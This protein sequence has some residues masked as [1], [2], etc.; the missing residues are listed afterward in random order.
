MSGDM[1]RGN[2]R[3]GALRE[4]SLHASIKNYYALS[5]DLIEAPINGYMIDIVRGSCL[6]EIQ[7]GNFSSIKQK[8]K[9][10]LPDYRVHL[11]YPLAIDKWILKKN[12]DG[13]LK[14]RKSP[15][16][17]RIEHIFYELVNISQLINDPNF[18]FEVLFTREQEIRVPVDHTTRKWGWRRKK[19]TVSDRQLLEVVEHQVFRTVMDYSYF[20]DSLG[21]DIPFTSHDL[22]QSLKIPVRLSQKMLYCF[23][24]MGLITE[25]GKRKRSRLY[26]KV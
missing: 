5:S 17:G 9:K 6:I 12:S 10:L 14:K 24:R 7:T 20:L 25:I 3:I 23:I 15:K 13:E 16:K 26:I 4:S 22:S 21:S 2:I 19:W 18:S 11:I 1:F 8:L